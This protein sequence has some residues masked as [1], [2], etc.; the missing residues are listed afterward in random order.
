M[1][2]LQPRPLDAVWHHAPTTPPGRLAELADAARR[3]LDGKADGM[4]LAS[5]AG[6][7]FCTHAEA[8]DAIQALG[9]AVAWFWPSKGW[10][11]R[12]RSADERRLAAANDNR[13]TGRIL[14][15]AA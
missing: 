1:Y 11:V 7:L 2:T 6:T 5:L 15:G 14:E 13:P 8:R 10:R 12:L 3:I 9:S 4:T